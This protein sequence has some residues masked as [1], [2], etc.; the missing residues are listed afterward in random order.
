MCGIIGTV[1]G[2]PN[3]DATALLDTL[4]HRGPDGSGTWTAGR[5]WLG[6]RRLAIIDLSDGGA[7]PMTKEGCGTIVFNGEIYDHGVHRAALE[8]DGVRFESRSD[9]EVLLRGLARSGPAFLRG[10]HGMYAFAW[11]EPGGDRLWLARDHAGMKPLYVWCRDGRVAFASELR[12]LAGAVRSL[13]GAVRVNPAAL[14]GFL[15]WGSVPEPLTTLAHVEMVPQDAALCVDVA[16]GEIARTERIGTVTPIAPDGGPVPAV[17]R[18]VSAAVSR[19]LVSDTPV[20]LF[21]SGGV[22]SSILAFEAARTRGPKPTAITVA[23]GSHGTTDEPEL[24][25]TLASALGIAFHVVHVDDWLARLEGVV[26]AFDQPSIDGMNT[27]LIAGVA[28]ELGFKVA[29]SGV[30]ADEV[31]GGYHHLHR[32]RVPLGAL[33][34]CGLTARLLGPL[35]A[36]SSRPAVRRLGALLEGAAA[37]EPQQRSWRRVLPDSVIRS[38]VRELVTTRGAWD[39]ADPLRLEQTT[40]LR[41]TLLR[42]T[43]VMGMARGVEI[44]APFL[45]PEILGAARGI[46]PSLVL[47]RERAPKWLLR[48]GWGQALVSGTLTRRKTGFTLDVS[49]WLLGR[50]HGVI[51]RTRDGLA[52]QR[53][54]ERDAATRL[55]DRCE[56]QLRS[57]HP[58]AW[59]PLFALA[60]AQEQ[61]RRWGEPA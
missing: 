6:H 19:H 38:L 27:Y 3:R 51:E 56:A 11:V 26:D 44:R 57:G 10:I 4:G 25:R 24:A 42:D 29:I 54:I 28:R 61:L 2:A 48:E 23:L 46:G 31:F 59:A 43:D 20:A 45:D 34:W 9:T 50:G 21:L 47:A 60:Q 55:L 8:R 7:Q 22:D 41:D 13:G 37:G 49:A 12:A 36:A 17:R 35:M 53:Y 40:Y 58:G 15:A 30:G 14:S 33:P 18:A 5:I 52:S 16:R 39:D 32:R 1:A